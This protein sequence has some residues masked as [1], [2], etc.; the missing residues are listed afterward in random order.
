MPD[1][2][3][4]L[5][6]EWQNIISPCKKFTDNTGGGNDISNQV[7]ATQDNL[8]LLS[9]FEVFGRQDYANSAEQNFQIQYQYFQS[10]NDKIHFKH[11][12]NATP[13]YWWLRSP[14]CSNNTS[15]CRVDISGDENTFN[16]LY[17]FGVV[18]C[19]AVC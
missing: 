19:F 11:N 7:T 14:Q 12:D 15:F 1:I 9:E 3:N 13:C 18:P 4:A 8:F 16:A 5:P 10:G 6:L 17:S 2:F